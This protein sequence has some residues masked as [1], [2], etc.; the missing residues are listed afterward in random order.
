MSLT[1]HI[2]FAL[3]IINEGMFWVWRI[4][5][6]SVS[7]SAD[8]KDVLIL[9]E[10]LKFCALLYFHTLIARLWNL[11]SPTQNLA[12]ILRSSFPRPCMW[13][14]CARNIKRMFAFNI[15]QRLGWNGWKMEHAW[16][17][18]YSHTKFWLGNL[19]GR[20]RLG[21]L[22]VGVRATDVVISVQFI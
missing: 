13:G 3:S 20:Y 12:Q 4:Y 18:W 2:T 14:K 19:K 16:V 11:I 21:D 5:A 10:D 15:N 1:T 22:G 6:G 9:L 7:F 8:R 17:K